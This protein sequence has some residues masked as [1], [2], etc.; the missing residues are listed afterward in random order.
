MTW[1]AYADLLHQAAVAANQGGKGVSLRATIMRLKAVILRVYR[2][3]CA[4]EL[5]YLMVY[6]VVYQA[7]DVK[8]NS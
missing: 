1:V 2:V 3:N 5:F 4:R 8:R 7:E 6:I